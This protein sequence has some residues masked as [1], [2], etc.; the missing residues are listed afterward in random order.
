MLSYNTW[1][2]RKRAWDNEWK[3]TEGGPSTEARYELEK[4]PLWFDSKKDWLTQPYLRLEKPKLSIPS[5][6][7]VR[8]HILIGAGLIKPRNPTRPF[9]FAKSE[10]PFGQPGWKGINRAWESQVPLRAFGAE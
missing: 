6:S 3:I 10:Q 9:E 4:L 1:Q 7:L 5:L 2:T 8:H